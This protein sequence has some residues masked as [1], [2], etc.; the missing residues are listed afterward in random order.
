VTVYWVV[1][2]GILILLVGFLA[3]ELTKPKG[4]GAEMPSEYA[5]TAAE[6]PSAE[7]APE[8]TPSQP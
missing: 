7:E 5:P 2:P 3:Y 1:I 6:E 4:Q 8:Q